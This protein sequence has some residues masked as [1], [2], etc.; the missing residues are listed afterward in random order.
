LRR[1]FVE[2]KHRPIWVARLSLLDEAPTDAL[3]RRP[4]TVQYRGDLIARSVLGG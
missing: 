3:H 2:T 4:T 1:P